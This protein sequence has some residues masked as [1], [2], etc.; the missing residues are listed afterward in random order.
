MNELLW[1][2]GGPDFPLD[3]QEYFEI[4][5][6]DPPNEWGDCYIVRRT[7]FE[8][9]EARGEIVPADHIID[10]AKTLDAAMARYEL[11]RQ[12]LAD[13]GFVYSDMDTIL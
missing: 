6:Q 10:R 4:A 5:L 13:L 11:H 12:I 9:D 8:W 7:H 3:Q 1:K 2:P